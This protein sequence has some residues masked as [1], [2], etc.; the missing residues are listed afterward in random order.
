MVKHTTDDQRYQIY[1]SMM[2]ANILSILG[3]FFIVSVYLSFKSL[4][5]FA[6]KLIL[7][8]SLFDLGNSVAFLIPTWSAESSSARCQAQAILTSFFTFAGVLWTTF[9]A[10]S[11]YFIIGKSRLFPEKYWKHILTIIILTCVIETVVPLT[12]HSYGTVAGWCW[13]VQTTNLDAGFYERYF[14][15]FVPLWCMII[16]III[17]YIFLIKTVRKSYQDE[18]T[19]KSL[20]KKLTYYPIIL[21]ICFLPYTVKGLLELLNVSFALEQQVLLTIFAGVS[22]SLVGFLNAVVYGYTKRVRNEIRAFFSSKGKTCGILEVPINRPVNI[23]GSQCTLFSEVS[24]T[25]E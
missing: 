7:I 24:E 4:H 15:F 19:V 20:N 1:I 13:I 18:S 12:T 22:R 6:F 25:L 17:L 16:L 8:L 5:K 14:L 3:C 9:I 21:I 10:I 2:P 23:Q 11:L